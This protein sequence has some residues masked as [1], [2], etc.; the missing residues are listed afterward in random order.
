MA[1]AL[2]LTLETIFAYPFLLRTT[3]AAVAPAGE[4]LRRRRALLAIEATLRCH[5]GHQ[6]LDVFG[7]Q[8]EVEIQVLPDVLLRVGAGDHSHALVQGPAQ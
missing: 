7:S 3:A 5:A 6:E 2:L 4:V 1:E 8:A